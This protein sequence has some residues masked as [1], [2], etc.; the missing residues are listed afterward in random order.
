L[1]PSS[2]GAALAAAIAIFLIAASTSRLYVAD[3]RLVILVGAMTLYVVGN[4][5]MVVVMRGMGLGIAISA[6]TI[7]Q[8]VLINVIAFAI[9]NERPAP[10]QLVGIGLGAVSMVLILFPLGQK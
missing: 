6:A 2:S 3:G 1:N 7:A 8:L 10:A 9:F 4:L 5:L